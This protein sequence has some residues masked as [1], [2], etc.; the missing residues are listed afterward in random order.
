[1][2]SSQRI[3]N[4]VNFYENKMQTQKKNNTAVKTKEKAAEKNL[5]ERSQI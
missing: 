1:M 3:T 4:V 5:L 2:I